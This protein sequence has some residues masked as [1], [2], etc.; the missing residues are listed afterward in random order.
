MYSGPNS[1]PLRDG[2]QATSLDQEEV[3]RILDACILHSDHWNGFRVAA[4]VL[5]GTSMGFRGSLRLATY[6][7]TRRHSCDATDHMIICR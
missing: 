1:D 6:L 3:Q 5:L 4:M 7:C 2:F